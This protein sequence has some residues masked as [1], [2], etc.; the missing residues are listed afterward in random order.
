MKD[1]TSTDYLSRKDFDRFTETIP[2]AE[3]KESHHF[4]YATIRDL[5]E[6]LKG[7][8]EAN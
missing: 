5:N 8:A 4:E 1:K 6:I 7:L 3:L 2:K